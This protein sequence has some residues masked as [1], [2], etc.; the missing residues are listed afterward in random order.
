VH[1]ADRAG[2][3]VMGMVWLFVLAVV[4]VRR[5]QKGPGG[6]EPWPRWKPC[7]FRR[8]LPLLF[9]VTAVVAAAG[10]ALHAPN[11][12]D[13]LSY[14]FPRMLHWWS[15]L[16]W[17][18]IV[19]PNE[20]MNLS[21]TG[22]EWMMMPFFVITHS[23]RLFFLI[24]IAAYSL[25]PSFIFVILI[26][27]GV[28]R[29]VAWFW[30]WLLPGAL[31]YAMQAGSISND[32]I[33]ATYFMAAIY[34]AYHARRTGAVRY[35][36][37]SFLAAGLLT[38]I[39]ASNL[40]LLLPIAWAMWPALRLV[41]R[42][43]ALGLGVIGVS[44]V[45]SFLP[46]AAMNLYHT[47]DWTGDPL[48][49]EQIKVRKPLAGVVGNV[50]QLG[51]KSL[52]PPFLPLAHSV[53]IWVW[54]GFPAGLQKILKDDFP[55]FDVGLKELP[56][57]ESAG[58]GG[59]ITVIVLISIVFACHRRRRNP[60]HLGN[61]AR[62]EGVILGALTWVSLLV[63]MSKMGSEA[64]SRLIAP[65]YP[66]L[67]LPLLLTS[68][69]DWLV[70]KRWYQGLGVLAFLMAMVAVIL[71]PARP[72]W[73]ADPVCEWAV[74]HFPE[75]AVLV[76]ARDIFVT[77]KH[78]N[79]VMAGLR[80]S[81]PDSVKVIGLIEGDNDIEASLWRPYGTRRVAHIQAGD[82]GQMREL[83]WVVVKNEIIA[84]GHPKGFER[85]LERSGG[86]IVTQQF[87]TEMVAAGPEVWSVIR[88]GDGL[89]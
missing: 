38:G 79:D 16:G 67:L 89:K 57:E 43:F 60:G 66:L 13:A 59:G 30:M 75:N 78:R 55:R 86:K 58:L 7:R 8:A 36:W 41:K 44:V 76:R 22:F 70:R 50:L 20:R 39:K 45:V 48:N 12:Y 32:T 84:P 31:C 40:P 65:Y 47:G 2:Y 64:T 72:L 68:A 87:V 63:Y 82:T 77:Y 28:A 15:G 33:A 37:L 80:R 10:G 11:N 49:S 18:W 29:R 17:H 26:A 85:W 71:T 1:E 9:L 23:D 54:N 83:G 74:K 14:R 62:R 56:Q 24:N 34:Y 42:R 46:C 3:L 52:E 51:L 25:L 73:P 6:R 4:Y 5:Q 61:L 69:Q 27:V 53:E 35:L 88:F 21:G 19:T 81:I